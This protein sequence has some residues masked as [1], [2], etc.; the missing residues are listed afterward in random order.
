MIRPSRKVF[1]AATALT[2]S[3]GL[4]ACGAGNEGGDS[5]SGEGGDASSAAGTIKGA[6]ASSMEKAQNE[7]IAKFTEEA[8]DATVEYAPD[9]SGTGREKFINGAVNF[10]GTDSAMDDEELAADIAYLKKLWAE[11]KNRA[12]GARRAGN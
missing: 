2:L 6:G 11:I 9:G 1:T 4:A 10:A 12:I 3:L 8:P 5:S 7:W